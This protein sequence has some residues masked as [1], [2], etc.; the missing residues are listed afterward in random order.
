MTA[1]IVWG[2]SA[3]AVLQPH[4]RGMVLRF[5]E[6]RAS[7]RR[8]RSAL[9]AA[10]ADR[11]GLRFP[12][13]RSGERT[14]RSWRAA[15]RRRAS[16]VLNLGTP[17]PGGEGPILWTNDHA[18][19]EIIRGR[20][21]VRGARRAAN[22]R[23]VAIVAAELPDALRGLGCAEGSIDSRRPRS[24]DAVA[25]RRGPA[26]GDAVPG[27]ASTLDDL[28]GPRRRARSPRRLRVEINGGVRRRSMR[29][30]R[31]SSSGSRASTRPARW[32]RTTRASIKAEQNVL[33]K[34]GLG[35]GRRDPR[36]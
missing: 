24:R 7:G 26:R 21:G 6:H 22:K 3:V 13:T 16:R 31:S 23:D 36:H 15:A 28:L 20:A 2:L 8:A 29:A 18:T 9:Q 5:G 10:L 11:D 27:G 19:E 35:Q 34:P 33:A 30:S 25:P 14:A 1:L 17:P 4:Q 32:R 12:S